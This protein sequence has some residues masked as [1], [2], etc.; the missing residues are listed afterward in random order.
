[1]DLRPPRGRRGRTYT[2]HARGF[3]TSIAPWPTVCA[4]LTPAPVCVRAN[5]L[6]A[7]SLLHNLRA[8]TTPSTPVPLLHP[9]TSE[10]LPRVTVPLPGCPAPGMCCR[11]HR[12]FG[13]FAPTH[14]TSVL[15]RSCERVI[16]LLYLIYGAS[17]PPLAYCTHYTC[18]WLSLPDIGGGAHRV[19]CNLTCACSLLL[20]TYR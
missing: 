13:A 2:S 14:H 15:P 1:M 5:R 20:C 8:S 11:R 9:S 16:L 17:E 18:S 10:R 12:G 3:S 19:A 7:P 4:A 6:L